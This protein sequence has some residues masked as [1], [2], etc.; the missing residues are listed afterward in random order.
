MRSLSAFLLL[1]FFLPAYAQNKDGPDDK[2]D[3]K[4]VMIPMRD[5][6]SLHT[7]IYTPKGQKEALPFL[8]ERTPY[9]ARNFSSPEKLLYIKDMAEGGFIFVFL[10]ITGRVG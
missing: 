8:M 6:V 2:Y 4:E 9:G 7:V 5:G 3:R 1:S 10:G